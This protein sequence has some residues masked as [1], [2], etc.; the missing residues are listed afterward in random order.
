MSL[1]NRPLLFEHIPK[2]GG[3]TFRKLL[4]KMYGTDRVFVINSRNIKSS[5]DEFSGFP[6]EKRTQYRVIAGHGAQLFGHFLENPFRVC[7]VREPISLFLSQYYY[8]RTS[9]K[10]VFWEDVNKLASADAYIEYA[11]KMGHD[12]M[13]TRFLSNSIQ[14]ILNPEIPIPAMNDKGDKQLEIAI[15]SMNNFDALMDLSNF[16]AGVYAFGKKLGWPGW[17]P[18]YAPVNRTKS[19]PTRFAPS[20]EFLHRLQSVL[21]YDIA[22]FK[23]FQHHK[24]DIAFQINENNTSFRLFLIRQQMAKQAAR[25]LGK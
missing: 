15:N 1:I 6:T 21:K 17:V 3:I 7:I 22:L 18:L 16:D 23:H 11:L 12:N 25:L 5:L 20:E 10:D 9:K 24:M 13:M 14:Y 4:T 19:K 8:L 2:T